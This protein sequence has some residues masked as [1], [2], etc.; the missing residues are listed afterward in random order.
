[1]MTLTLTMLQLHRVYCATIDEAEAWVERAIWWRG[2]SDPS[3]TSEN[4]AAEYADAALAV[5]RQHV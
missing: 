5:A 3:P 1:M 2:Q 4:Y